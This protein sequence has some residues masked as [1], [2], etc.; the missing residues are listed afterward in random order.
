MKTTNKTMKALKKIFFVGILPIVT[1]HATCSKEN[2]S[3]CVADAK[4]AYN[5]GKYKKAIDFLALPCQLKKGA[6]CGLI[7][8]IYRDGIGDV[9]KDKAKALSY[10]TMACEGGYPKSC[11]DLGI[12]YQAEGKV[13]SAIKSYT[14]GCQKND[15]GSCYN[16]ASMYYFGAGIPKSPEKAKNFYKKAC[17]LGDKNQ[18]CERYERLSGMV[19]KKS[20]VEKFAQG[21]KE[22]DGMACHNLGTYFYNGKGVKQ[23]YKKALQFDEFACAYEYAMG[24]K[25]AALEYYYGKHVK[26]DIK[27]AL[28]L[29]IRAGA[30]G[31][32]SGFFNAGNI[33]QYGKGVQKDLKLAKELYMGGCIHE[34]MPSC[35][36]LGYFFEKGLTEKADGDKAAWFYNE[37]CKR[38]E[39]KGCINMAFLYYEGKVVEQDPLKAKIYF[40]KACSLGDEASCKNSKAIKVLKNK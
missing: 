7:G 37:A 15:V 19:V 25:N 2:L 39:K 5:Q 40:E 10:I 12:F 30:L 20:E 9:P 13:D 14:K 38:K 6:P 24:C 3:G 33:Y 23:D 4:K 35:V 16:L 28:S 29:F 11:M 21:C 17:E 31:E 34:D 26:K 8:A 1:L 36:K 18:A 32:K 27:M 22:K